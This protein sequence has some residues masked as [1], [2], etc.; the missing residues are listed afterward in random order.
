MINIIIKT[1]S[2]NQSQKD[3]PGKKKIIN[4]IDQN[5]LIYYFKGN[6]ARK[7]FDNFNN[8]TELFVK[9]KS[10][11]TKL[12]KANNQ[13]NVFKPNLNKNSRRRLKLEALKIN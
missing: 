8:D 4:K 12:E 1:Y 5:N 6:T 10:S 9:R 7:R 13:Q 11:E 3:L 2:T